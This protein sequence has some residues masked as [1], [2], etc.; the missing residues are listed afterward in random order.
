MGLL[1]TGAQMGILMPY[2]RAHESE[3][4]LMGLD[5]M[6]RAGFDPRQS[7]ALWQNMAAEGGAQ[8]PEF[9]STHPSHGTRIADLNRR[10][11]HAME[12]FV[13]AATSRLIPNCR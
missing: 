13:E 8:P 11:S 2:G 6:A 12:L 3:A 5:L 9:L 10:M 7:V 1:G 4:D